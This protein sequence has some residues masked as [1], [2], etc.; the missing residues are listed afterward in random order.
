[1]THGGNTGPLKDTEHPFVSAAVLVLFA[2][3]V[4]LGLAS[5]VGQRSPW[6][7]FTAAI[8]VA[9]GRYGV[10]T[11]VFAMAL[12]FALGMNTFV[13]SAYRSTA[14][15]VTSLVVFLVV[16]AAM[17]IFA[18]RLKA[19]QERTLRLQAQLQQAHTEAA[20]GTMASTLAH[21]LN[22]PL[23]AATNYLAACK[24][25]VDRLDG[26]HKSKVLSGLS[27]TEDQ[28]QRAGEIIREA[29]DMVRNAAAKRE[30]VSLKTMVSRVTAPLVA[31]GA[32]EQARIR[33]E[34][35]ESADALYANTIQIE[36][37]LMNLLRNACQAGASNG[38]ADVLVL[39]KAE[40][41]FTIT[42]VRD[43]GPGIPP[44]RLS[45]LFLAKGQS[46]QGGLGLGLSISK[47]IVESH[48]GRIWAVN[49]DS[50]GASLFFSLPRAE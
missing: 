26:D 50:G 48:G 32:C 11:G 40:D 49:N 8:V 17:L 9:A 37:V 22:Q 31:T 45:T 16:G 18:A 43:R 41:R 10:R 27:E 34:V 19:T 23:A 5:L 47:T 14:E 7:L 39:A 38:T 21:E 2:Y 30:R 33:T 15:A 36:Q 42:E 12:S 20:V 4:R 24:R 44:D 29:R 1:M 13:V 3:F 28:I 46:T 35:E 6:L 25:L